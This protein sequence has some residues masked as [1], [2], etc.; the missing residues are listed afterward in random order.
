MKTKVYRISIDTID[1]NV[2]LYRVSIKKVNNFQI[3]IEWHNSILDSD[4]EKVYSIVRTQIA[5]GRNFSRNDDGIKF[6][7]PISAITEFVATKHFE[8]D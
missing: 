1:G 7:Y 8:K 5:V 2:T 4:L 3:E 6:V